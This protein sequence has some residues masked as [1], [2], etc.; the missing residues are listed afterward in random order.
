M[1]FSAAKFESENGCF[2][3]CVTAGALKAIAALRIDFF[4]HI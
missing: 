1:R 2:E 4:T 3:C